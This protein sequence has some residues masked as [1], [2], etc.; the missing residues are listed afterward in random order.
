MESWLKKLLALVA[1]MVVLAGSAVAYLLLTFDPNTYKANLTDWVQ[2]E[3]QRTLQLNGPIKLAFWPRLQVHLQDVTLSDFQ[4]PEEFAHFDDLNLAVQVMPLLKG[5]LR[6]EQVSMEGARLRYVRDAKGRSNIDDLL[7]A[8][9]PSEASG[10]KDVVFDIAGVT[11]SN[12]QIELD[13]AQTGV[14]GHVA[15]TSFQSG[16]LAA[17]LATD[18]DVQTTVQL[19]QPQEATV[20]LNGSLQLTP[21]LAQ[22][23]F[24]AKA[25]KMAVTVQRNAQA[26]GL[27]ALNVSSTLQAD[28]AM[29][30]GLKQAAQANGL[31]IEAEGVL[32]SGAQA[33][34]LQALSLTAEQLAFD[35]ATQLLKLN[36]LETKLSAKQGDQTSKL[37]LQWPNL[38]VEGDRLT[39]SALQAH[40]EV[41]GKVSLTSDIKS[42]PPSGSFDAITLPGLVASFKVEMPGAKGSRDISGQIKTLLKIQPKAMAGS[43]N[44]LQLQASVQEPSLQPLTIQASGAL[45]AASAQAMN[46]RSN[47][48]INGN[49]FSTQGDVALGKGKPEVKATARFTALDLNRLLPQSTA[50]APESSSEAKTAVDPAVDLSALQ[51]FNGRL[52]F[53]AGQLVYQHYKLSNA[54]VAARVSQGQLT[55]ERLTA[56]AWGGQIQA[57][58]QARAGQQTLQLEASGDAVDVQALLKDVA[59]K[60]V[61]E[62][63]GDV[64][65]NV[66]SSGQTVSAMRSNLQGTASM[67]LRDGAVRGINLAKTFREAKAKLSG[68]ADAVQQA[69]QTEKT[70]F[71]NLGGTWQ[72]DKGIARNTDMAAKS[73]LLRVTGAGQIDLSQLSMDYTVKATLT[74]TLEGQDGKDLEQLKGLTVPVRLTGPFSALAWR[75]SWSDVAV[76]AVTNTLKSQLDGK[77]DDVR[78]KAK[79]QLK[80]KLLGALGVKPPEASSSAASA[81]APQSAEDALKSGLQNKLKGLFK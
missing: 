80:G 64:R 2:Q 62:G 34:Q 41:A 49:D 53:Q 47:G 38:S 12:A 48:A 52:D 23:R 67:M 81:P 22:K 63:K 54:I 72:I 10:S 44:E 1:L 8:S 17:G 55:M 58:G 70:D 78:D 40:V 4:K 29:W 73:P 56:G 6:V 15:L 61:L 37:S 24:T 26:N 59:N 45:V 60:D 13:D 33:M 7:V 51:A 75:I 32:G 71:T 16:R 66:Q 3:K 35:P 19:K 79:D 50:S 9:E 39:G 14:Q 69:Q 5:Q 68:Q 36:D 77:V 65:L 21:D 31:T 30:D 11:L 20:T 27:S 18:M 74:G 43:L 42:G 25:L 76:G 46:W 57:K 28:D